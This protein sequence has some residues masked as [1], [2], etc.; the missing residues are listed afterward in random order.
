MITSVILGLVP[1]IHWQECKATSQSD[2]RF[3]SRRLDIQI[4]SIFAN[5]WGNGSRHQVPGQQPWTGMGSA[6]IPAYSSQGGRRAG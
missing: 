5:G 3:A 1:G 6:I 2:C 4:G